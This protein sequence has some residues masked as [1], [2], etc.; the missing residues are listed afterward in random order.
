MIDLK[1]TGHADTR[2]HYYRNNQASIPSFTGGV[3]PEVIESR[4]DYEAKIYSPIQADITRHAMQEILD[5][6]W[7]N[8]RG[9]IAR[10]ERGSIEI[11]VMDV[12]ECPAADIAIVSL[13]T[14]TL[15]W[16][17]LGS[18]AEDSSIS[19]AALVSIFESTISSGEEALITDE[20]YLAIFDIATPARA[21]EVWR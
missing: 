7:V 18:A 6:V 8:S 2:L 16:L 10:F 12:Q 9:A 13:V 5:P 4:Q 21:G 20:N 1:L 15:K 11:R 17:I 3:I 14:E 19:T